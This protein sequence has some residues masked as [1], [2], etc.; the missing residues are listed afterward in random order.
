MT[1]NAFLDFLFWEHTN[2]WLCSVNLTNFFSTFSFPWIKTI[3]F[4][5]NVQNGLFKVYD[6]KNGQL[7]KFY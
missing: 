7:E 2:I 6:Q 4:N 5:L 1:W 3:T